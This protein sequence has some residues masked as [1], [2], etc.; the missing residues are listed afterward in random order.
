[1][2]E[3]IESEGH[4]P[5]PPYIDRADAA[6]DRERYQTVYARDAG[7][8]AAPTA[9]LHFTDDALARCRAAGADL[10]WVTLHVGAGTFLPLRVENVEEVKLHAEQW[11]MAASVREAMAK[12]ARVLAVGTTSMRTL[13]SAART[14][15]LAGDT[16][17]FISPGFEFRTVQGLVTNFHLP[18]SSL[19]MLVCAF[20]GM[21]FALA[22]Y[23]H[24]IEQRYRFYS[25]GD[26]MLII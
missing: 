7:S 6:H 1:V 17:I 15:A 14:D 24:A 11:R 16:D 18:G 23:R 10:Q 22:A 2:R 13:E 5:L 4:I 19:V 20:A 3:A 8:V 25:Y 21:D 9:G 26:C 12:A